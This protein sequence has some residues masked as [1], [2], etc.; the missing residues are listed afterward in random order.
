MKKITLLLVVGSIIAVARPTGADQRKPASAL[1]ETTPWLD[2]LYARIDR[3]A[4][5]GRPLVVLVHVP[6]C[7]GAI[8]NCGNARLGLPG[9]LRTNLYWATSEGTLHAFRGWTP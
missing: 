2:A 6:L 1:Q 4:A 5:A 8:I 7:D 9:N 3:D